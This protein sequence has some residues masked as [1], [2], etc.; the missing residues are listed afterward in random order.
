MM[1]SNKCKI[2]FFIVAL[3]GFVA[4]LIIGLHNKQAS[5][6]AK[7]VIVEHFPVMSVTSLPKS[8]TLLPVSATLP[9]TPVTSLSPTTSLPE[10]QNRQ[11]DHLFKHPYQLVN[12]WASWCG[13]CQQE[14]DYLKQLKQQ[15]VTIIGLN[16]RDN[17]SNAVNYLTELGNPYSSVIYD[18]QG[19]LSID[20]GVIGTP[21]TY[22][23]TQDGEIISKFAGELNQPAWNTHFAH[24]FEQE[25]TE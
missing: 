18:P 4:F 1:L 17:H 16:Y 23:V 19:K 3:P 14:H 24:Y 6:T 2:G 21:E 20:L 25:K 15:G 10:V 5:S 7:P 9:S 13:V 12:V 8:V 11:T 22:L